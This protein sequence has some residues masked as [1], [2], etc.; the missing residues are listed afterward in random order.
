M[1]KDDTLTIEMTTGVSKME[2]IQTCQFNS[3]AEYL[4]F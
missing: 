4:M 2:Q 3:L 1:D